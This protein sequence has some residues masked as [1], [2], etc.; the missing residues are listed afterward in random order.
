MGS[1]SEKHLG[2]L[3]VTRLKIYTLI[4][5]ERY[6]DVVY[7]SCLYAKPSVIT[8]KTSV[9]LNFTRINSRQLRNRR[10]L[11]PANPRFFQV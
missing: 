1:F 2:I 10:V 8:P 4:I 9:K 7:A 6:L 5:N 11:E 3:I